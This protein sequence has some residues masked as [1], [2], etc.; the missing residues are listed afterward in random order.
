[1]KTIVVSEID[2]IAFVKLNRPD[3]R[4]AFNAE[5]ISELTAVFKM[6]QQRTDLRAV[7]LVGEGTVFCAG[8]DLNWMKSMVHY[9]YE[10]NKA[11]SEKLYSMFDAL[12]QLD[13]PVVSLVQG[14]V[15]GGA[16]GLVANCDYVIA[17]TGTKFCF[18]EVKLGIAPAVISS[19]V[20]NKASSQA[21]YYMA[22]AEVFDPNK[23]KDLGLV[24]SVATRESAHKEF[25]VAL[26]RYKENGP[27][28][29]RKTKQLIRELNQASWSNHKDLTTRTIAELRVSQEGQ[30]GIKSFLENKSPSWKI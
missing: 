17:E 13:L 21:K 15:F 4:N 3:V 27:L 20:L 10:E 18:S 22:S 1:M 26:H 25:Q 29:V 5:M 8:A 11:D 14:A 7:G 28:A 12:Y 16:L 30:D 23:A 24:N 9:S 2:Q 6:L 19:F